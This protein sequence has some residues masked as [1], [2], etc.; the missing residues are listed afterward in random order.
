MLISFVA[1]MLAFGAQA[2][3]VRSQLTSAIEDREPTDDLANDVVGH[4]N[5]ITQ[6]Y[7]FNHLTNMNGK[8]LQHKWLLDGVEKAV[9]DLKIGSN[10]WRTYSSKRMNDAMQGNWQ[11]QVWMD[12]QQL[13]A[14]EF[15][16]RLFQ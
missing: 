15:T 7:Y 4:S 10:N 3:I 12:G 13:Q 2:D 6:V 9:I 1:L 14:H 11:V 8:V 16:Y 5:T